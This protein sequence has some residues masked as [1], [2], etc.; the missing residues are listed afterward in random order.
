MSFENSNQNG[1]EAYQPASNDYLQSI[2]RR[3]DKREDFIARK[4]RVPITRIPA[5]DIPPP[6]CLRDGDILKTHARLDY[7]LSILQREYEIQA[8]IQRYKRARAP[9]PHYP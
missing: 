8:R 2:L 6:T 1:K 7:L 5:N 4:E 9:S 3:Q